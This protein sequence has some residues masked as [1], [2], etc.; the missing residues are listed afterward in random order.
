MALTPILVAET[1]SHEEKTVIVVHHDLQTIREYYEWVFLLNV[2]Q[3]AFGRVETTFTDE[4]LRLT[5][6]GRHSFIAQTR[7]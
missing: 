4:N 2:R 7:S 1:L 3:I 6:G 5:Y